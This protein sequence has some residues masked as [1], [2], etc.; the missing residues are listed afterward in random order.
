[1]DEPALPPMRSVN[2]D[3]EDFPATD[4]GRASFWTVAPDDEVPR[5]ARRAFVRLGTTAFLA[6]RR[7]VTRPRV[8]IKATEGHPT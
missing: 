6:C 4:E 1:M 2:A 5:S 7:P 8:G 3:V